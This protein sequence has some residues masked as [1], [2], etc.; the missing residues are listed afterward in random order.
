MNKTAVNFAIENGIKKAPPCFQSR[1]ISTW[2]GGGGGLAY[3]TVIVAE[4]FALGYV[5][6]T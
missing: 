1:K 5:F 6:V 2:Q 3:Y 4:S